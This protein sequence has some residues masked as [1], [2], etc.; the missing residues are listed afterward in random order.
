MKKTFLALVLI[1]V[2]I[3]PATTIHASAQTSDQS[4]TITGA[5]STFIFP[6]MDTWRVQYNTLHPNIQLNYQSIGSGAGITL[7]Q[8]KSVDFAAS[9]APLQ[10]NEAAKAVGVLTI[11]D[12]IGGITISYNIPG[13]GKDLKLTGPVIAR[14]FMGNITSWN[15]PAIV[16]LNPGVNLPDQKIITAHRADGSGT[17]YA[18]TDYLSKVSPDWKNMV[19]QGKVVPWPVGTGAQ[20]NAGVASIV[21]TTPYACGYVELAYAYQNNFT[22]A[23]VQNADGNAFV[24]PT[25]DTV[26]ADAA[27]AGSSLPPADGDW[28][29]VSI[30]N[31]PGS[32][33]YPIS[34]FT[35]I[36]VYKDL[37]Q[38]SGETQG[39]ATEV[40]NFLNWITHDGQKYSTSLLYIPLP[41]SVVKIDEQGLAEI[42]FN[43][44]TVPEFGPI[45]ALVLAIA[46][47]SII[48]VSART[49]LRFTPKF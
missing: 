33:S 46:I 49:N 20:G 35:Y 5:G 45:T 15:D 42:Q 29:K 16:N 27:A 9:D 3:V 43:G 34:T 17:T 40:V 19:G 37:G 7:L 31:E 24:E 32:N 26:A 44:I 18:F 48:A 36:M 2:L 8:H 14:I 39:R 23:V 25:I 38:V 21:K 30:V 13:V 28:S 1:L 47:I 12:S 41:A 22:Y 4:Y 10:P 6:L 11:P